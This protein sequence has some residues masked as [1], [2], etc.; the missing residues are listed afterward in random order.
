MF[1]IEQLREYLLDCFLGG[2]S[3]ALFPLPTLPH[4]QVLEAPWGVPGNLAWKHLLSVPIELLRR[5]VCVSL[6]PAPSP[7]P[8]RQ[9]SLLPPQTQSLLLL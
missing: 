9:E 7:P 3:Q 5:D 1:K 4:P 6:H 8:A 2:W